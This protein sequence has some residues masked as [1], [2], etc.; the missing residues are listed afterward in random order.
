LRS[1]TLTFRV[2]DK[3][4]TV[5]PGAIVGNKRLGAALALVKEQQAACAPHQL[6]GLPRY[7]RRGDNS[8]NRKPNISA[9]RD[10]V[11]RFKAG[12]RLI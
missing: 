1:D 7:K 4:Q 6:T 12:C 5:E 2:F 10:N 8:R 11:E 3:I 9:T